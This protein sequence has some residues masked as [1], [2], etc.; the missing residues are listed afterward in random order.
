[1]DVA[2]NEDALYTTQG[3]PSNYDEM[4]S[5]M[6]VKREECEL[7]S[8]SMLQQHTAMSWRGHGQTFS[9]RHQQNNIYLPCQT[10][11][12][13]ILQPISPSISDMGSF[14]DRCVSTPFVADAMDSVDLRTAEPGPVFDCATSATCFGSS[15]EPSFAEI[16]RHSTYVSPNDC[17]VNNDWIQDM[18][19]Y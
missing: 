17:F 5:D 19:A 6:I 15:L 1:M 11:E 3:L 7:L 14:S 9:L 2:F 10:V 18:I 8:T 4:L 13:D 12:A 16:H